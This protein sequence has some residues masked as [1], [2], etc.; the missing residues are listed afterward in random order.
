MTLRCSGHALK[1]YREHHKSATYTD[2]IVAC[3]NSKE[4]EKELIS[5]IV[6]SNIE[7]IFDSKTNIFKCAP[8]GRGILGLRTMRD[9]GKL[10]HTYLK[11]SPEQ[12]RALRERALGM[13]P[14]ILTLEMIE[15]DCLNAV[16]YMSNEELEECAL[17]ALRLGVMVKH[18]KSRK[19]VVAYLDGQSIDTDK[20]V[21]FALASWYYNYIIELEFGEI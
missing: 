3:E 10:I 15:Q 2:M 21:I 12:A 17:K 18:T 8:D 1:E 5:S 6:N 20:D 9:G 19:R 11:V 13:P 14:E 16:E 7:Q 4:V